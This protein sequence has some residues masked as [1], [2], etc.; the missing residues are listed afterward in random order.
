M[1]SLHTTITLAQLRMTGRSLVANQ[2]IV[3]LTK[4]RYLFRGFPSPMCLMAHKSHGYQLLGSEKL[5]ADLPFR[6]MSLS[7]NYA[8]HIY[9]IVSDIITTL[10]SAILTANIWNIIKIR[11]PGLGDTGEWKESQICQRLPRDKMNSC[12]CTVSI[13]TACTPMPFLQ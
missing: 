11:G 6:W 7:F 3:W 5:A 10:E 9:D 4:D 2:P 13:Y 12:L 1:R 8:I